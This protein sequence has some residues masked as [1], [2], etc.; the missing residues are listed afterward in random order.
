MTSIIPI[1]IG[2][3]GIQTSHKLWELFAIEH[4]IGLDG[5]LLDSNKKEYP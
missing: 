5:K 3:T 4:G 1:C 2:N